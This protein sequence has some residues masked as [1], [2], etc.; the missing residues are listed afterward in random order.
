MDPHLGQRDPHKG[1]L[2]GSGT[3]P[4]VKSLDDEGRERSEESEKSSAHQQDEEELAQ[5]SSEASYRDHNGIDHTA[6]YGRQEP[7]PWRGKKTEEELRVDA[8]L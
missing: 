7:S 1:S 6:D 8:K 5:P 4:Q 2:L 3:V